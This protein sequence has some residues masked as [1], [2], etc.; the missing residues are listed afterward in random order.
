MVWQILRR[1]SCL[2]EKLGA[3]TE[4]AEDGHMVPS[5]LNCFQQAGVEGDRALTMK[6]QISVQIIG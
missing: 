3:L 2:C 5:A 6:F 1:A 4:V